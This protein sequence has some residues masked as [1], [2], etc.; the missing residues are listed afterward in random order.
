MLLGVGLDMAD[1]CRMGSPFHLGIVHLKRRVL[2]GLQTSFD[3]LPYPG[4]KFHYPGK[5]PEHDG[6]PMPDCLRC[7]MET[8]VGSFPVE[9]PHMQQ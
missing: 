2:E 7:L 1:L 3:H 4:F 8:I 9:N 5:E 6:S